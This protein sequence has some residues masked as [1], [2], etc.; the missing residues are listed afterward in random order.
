MSISVNGIFIFSPLFD[1]IHKKE[2]SSMNLTYEQAYNKLEDI[3]ED[4]KKHP[5]K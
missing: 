1:I 4:I 2:V 3:L 5:K